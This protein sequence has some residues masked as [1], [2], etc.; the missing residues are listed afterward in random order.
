MVFCPPPSTP[1]PVA[2]S[3]WNDLR[4]LAEDAGAWERFSTWWSGPP[5]HGCCHPDYPHS[6]YHASARKCC[7]PPESS[8]KN[9]ILRVKMFCWCSMP[10]KPSR[11]YWR[12]I[13]SRGAASIGGAVRT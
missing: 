13:G 11:S 9:P 1:C 6:P 2:T 8:A 12:A 4:G 7:S 10:T 3:L 5:Q